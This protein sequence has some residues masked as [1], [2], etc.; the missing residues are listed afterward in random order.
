MCVILTWL[1]TEFWLDSQILCEFSDEWN[2]SRQ[3]GTLEHTSGMPFVRVD[4]FLWRD[5]SHPRV[6]RAFCLPNAFMLP[7]CILPRQC[8]LHV[9]A[10][11]MHVLAGLSLDFYYIVTM[12]VAICIVSACVHLSETLDHILTLPHC[13]T[14]MKCTIPCH[15]LDS[16]YDYVGSIDRGLFSS[17]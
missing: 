6:V 1:A 10:I 2:S 7:T 8:F 15:S 5:V 9:G 11:A 3:Q 13:V 17:C 16:L 12:V 14:M 4:H